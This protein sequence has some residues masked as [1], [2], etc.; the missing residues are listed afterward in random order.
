M[1]LFVFIDGCFWHGCPKHCRMPS[2]NVRYWKQKISGNRK[3]DERT[4]RHLKR[5]GW[6]VVSV[7]EHDV[8]NNLQKTI[9]RILRGIQN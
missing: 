3:R 4:S 8:K 5:D 7:W 6:K 9:E 2:S 1:A